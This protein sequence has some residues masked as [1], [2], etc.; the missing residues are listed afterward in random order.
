MAEYEKKDPFLDIASLKPP[1]ERWAGDLEVRDPK[2]SPIFGDL[3]G[4]H[5]V[6]VFIGTEEVLYPDVTKMFHMLDNDISNE[7]IVGEGMIH[8]YPLNPIEEAKPACRKIFHIVM[9]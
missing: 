1:A 5:N 3:K 9:R 8:C 6:T 2:I 4:I 7:L